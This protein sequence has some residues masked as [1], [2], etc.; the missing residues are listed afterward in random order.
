[1]KM[2]GFTAEQSLKQNHGSYSQRCTV[3]PEAAGE[4]R[5]QFFH[6]WILSIANQCCLDGSENC[7]ALVGNILSRSLGFG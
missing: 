3:L 2:P 6:A 1:M 4:V 7:C 5:P